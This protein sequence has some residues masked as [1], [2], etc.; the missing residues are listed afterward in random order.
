MSDNN[1]FWKT[2]KPFLLDKMTSTQKITLIDKE[3]I[4]MGDDN[5]VTLRSKD[6]RTVTL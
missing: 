5:I 6:I 4:I 3:D 1:T 2:I